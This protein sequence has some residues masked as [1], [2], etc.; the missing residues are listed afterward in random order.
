M[1][2]KLFEIDWKFEIFS[3]FRSFWLTASILKLN[4][5]Q[6]TTILDVVSKSDRKILLLGEC[7]KNVAKRSSIGVRCAHGTTKTY[8]FKSVFAQ[9]Q[10]CL[11]AKTE[12]LFQFNLIEALAAN[13][14]PVIFADNVILPFAEV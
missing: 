9:S 7:P 6:M 3:Y 8:D 11:I 4:E 12:R 1:Q 5:M 2:M 13:C 14:I 10:F